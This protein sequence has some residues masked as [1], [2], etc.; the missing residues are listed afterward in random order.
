MDHVECE[1]EKG[2][3]GGFIGIF[4]T[5]CRGWRLLPSFLLQSLA[6]AIP[7]VDNRKPCK[8]TA[9]I[10]CLAFRCMSVISPCVL[11]TCSMQDWTSPHTVTP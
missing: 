9:V 1:L 4:M 5:R 11:C 3:L 6:G 8:R 7:D 2:D 10:M